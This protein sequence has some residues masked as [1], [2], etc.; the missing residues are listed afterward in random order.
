MLDNTITLPV[1]VLNNGTPV[2]RVY[3]R[4]QEFLNRSVY[5]GPA[6][7][8]S[9][10]ETLGFYR[11]PVRK[12]GNDFGTAKSAVKFTEDI[13]VTD[14]AGVSVTK[15]AIANADFSFPVGITSAKALEMRQRLIAALD[16]AVA[17]ALTEQLSV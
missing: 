14:A 7:T 16:H 17:A 4:D 5:T 11:T 2:N 13:V 12:V 3:T 15:A 8:L 9:K 10:R 1:D 6:H